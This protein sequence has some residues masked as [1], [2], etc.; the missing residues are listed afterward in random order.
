M[1]FLCSCNISKPRNSTC[2]NHATYLY[3]GYTDDIEYLL[4]LEYTAVNYI[5]A[6][7]SNHFC[8]NYLKAALCVTIYPPCNDSGVQK[9]CYEECDSLL[10]NGICS[11]D[12]RY[13][14]QHVNNMS[15]N[16]YSNFTIDC[17]NSLN[18]L[19]RFSNADPCQSN[20]CV[21]LLD[22]TEFPTR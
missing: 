8:R 3:Y 19:G 7:V 20:S 5:E 9:L 15:S 10:N 1:I 16:A 13:L 2:L 18:F 11:S 17:F 4:Q 22:I 12:A 21:S 6:N 14:I